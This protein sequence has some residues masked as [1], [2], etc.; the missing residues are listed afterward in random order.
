[1][2]PIP[3]V[4]IAPPFLSAVL[5]AMSGL[6]CG[7]PAAA[8]MAQAVQIGTFDRPVYVAVAPGER[9]LLFI[10]EQGGRVR[11]MRGNATLA[12]AFLDISDIVRAPGDAGA[13]GEQGLFSIAFAPDYAATRRFYVAFTNQRGALEIGEFRRSAGDAAR[14]IR[15]SR[16][17]V[18]TIPH[19]GAQNHNGGQLQFGPDGL[20]YISTGDGGNAPAGETSRSLRSLLGKI[21]RIDPRPQ[22]S[23]PYR[24]PSDNPFRGEGR[25]EIFAYG[26]RNPWRF[27]FDGQRIAI[28]DVGAARR[29][30][31]NFLRLTNASGANFGWPQYEGNLLLDN[32]RPGPDPPVFP[33]FSYAHSAGRCAIIG[34]FV[35]RDP[36]LPRLMGRYLYGDLCTGQVRSFIPDVAGQVARNDRAVGV[37]LPGLTGFG[38]G[39]GGKLYLTQ[40]SGA[41]SRLAPP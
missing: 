6:A 1:M 22:G 11:V 18:I 9:R 30:E 27:S 35:A 41:V 7:P 33:M 21:L 20:L 36:G 14:A 10:V 3:R 19:P 8:Q 15:A 31:V 28:A 32:S 29:E 34:G 17:M 23:R 13:G 40:T 2:A 38:L 25:G 5:A 26:L 37:T 4:R 24:V 39:H 12:R 16:R